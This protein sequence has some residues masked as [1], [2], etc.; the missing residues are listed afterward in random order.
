MLVVVPNHMKS[1]LLQIFPG[2]DVSEVKAIITMQHSKHD[3]VNI[4]VDIDQ[5]KD[6]LLEK[7]FRQI[8]H[9]QC[10][11]NVIQY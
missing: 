11:V 6:D 8:C 3:L 1:E 9:T 10:I 7:V 4:G 5:E 2:V